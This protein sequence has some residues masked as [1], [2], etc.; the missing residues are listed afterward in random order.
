MLRF[1]RLRYTNA[2]ATI[3]YYDY[4]LRAQIFP[5]VNFNNDSFFHSDKAKAIHG[6]QLFPNLRYVLLQQDFRFANEF[7]GVQSELGEIR[8]CAMSD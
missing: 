8:M 5:V 7:Y 2:S 4:Y 1:V 3:Y 6:R